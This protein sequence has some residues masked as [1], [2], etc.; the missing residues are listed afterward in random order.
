MGL[1]SCLEALLADSETTL[2]NNPLCHSPEQV[3][4]K[5]DLHRRTISLTV[6]SLLQK[7][8]A[9]ALLEPEMSIIRLHDARGR[10]WPC[11]LQ[12]LKAEEAQALLHPAA[13]ATKP[14]IAANRCALLDG[15]ADFLAAEGAGAGDF[16][17]IGKGRPGG[18]E[19]ELQLSVRLLPG[20]VV[21][22]SPAFMKIVQQAMQAAEAMQAM[23][24]MDAMQA[25]LAMQTMQAVQDVQAVEAM[26]AVQGV[27]S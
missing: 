11:T 23:Q 25:V 21:A 17:R 10:C 27:P 2:S 12:G 16:L 1:F 22:A 13:N 3:L 20:A 14:A 8:T 26:Q 24:D 18:E 19:G 7:G 9:Q 15:L 4:T 6:R 5:T